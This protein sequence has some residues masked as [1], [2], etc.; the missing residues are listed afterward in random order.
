[1]RNTADES[2]PR[3]VSHAVYVLL[4]L[5]SFN[6]VS[7]GRP[8]FAGRGRQHPQNVLKER[9]EVLTPN[10]RSHPAVIDEMQR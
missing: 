10:D 6:D 9:P 8:E 1:M 2:D 4:E 7:R 3:L 5:L